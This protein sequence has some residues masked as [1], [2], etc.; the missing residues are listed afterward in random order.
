MRTR[1]KKLKDLIG[2][3]PY[4]PFFIFLFMLAFFFSRFIPVVVDLPEGRQR[5]QAAG[6]IL[7]ISLI[8]AIFLSLAATII[9]K[10]RFWSKKSLV[11]YICEIAAVQCLLLLY[12][13]LVRPILKE[14]LRYNYQLALAVSPGLFIGT[15]S[16]SLIAL[17]LMGRSQ[18]AIELKLD[19]AE[20]QN[21]KLE[22]D[23]AALINSDEEIR[24]QVSQFLHD[25]VQ[26][27]LMVS[28]MT[29][30]EAIEQSNDELRF[31]VPK[32][33]SRLE[34][35]RSVDLKMLTSIL[36]PN[37]A[38]SNLKQA[39]DNLA[40]Q[41]AIKTQ[42]TIEISD[43][44]FLLNDRTTLG[45][46]RIV[47]QALLNVFTHGPA[48]YVLVKINVNL[49]S[50]ISIEITDDGPGT[51]SSHIGVGTAIIDSWVAIL[52]GRKEIITSP[53]NGYKLV[54]QLPLK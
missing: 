15:L 26:S 3:Y 38:G 16:V 12:M 36:T 28:S 19:E 30:Q 43:Q 1:I 53:G 18:K 31:S 44:I 25:R 17:A 6:L 34:S 51:D 2:P 27:E 4:N 9:K 50:R 8:P 13:P 48:N 32:V 10:F 46:Y 39:I 40:K 37:F 52:G 42:F 41:Y 7:L 14:R 47:E 35:I 45:I 24:R 22:A 11:L 33:L 5:T 29:L 23:R 54:V 21:R 20:S 49:D